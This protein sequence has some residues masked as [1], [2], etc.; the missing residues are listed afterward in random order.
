MR[1]TTDR[2]NAPQGGV[3]KQSGQRGD[4][5]FRD[6]TGRVATATEGEDAMTRT[7]LW[8]MAAAAVLV[9]AAGGPVPAEA[10]KLRGKAAGAT[11][12]TTGWD[13]SHRLHRDRTGPSGLR[14][15]TSQP[16]PKVQTQE[17]NFTHTLDK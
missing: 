1:R 3:Q 2:S 7:S 14:A 6:A 8:S 12:R 4:V 15:R 17:L 11:A 16:K 5:R 9:I 10:A 13:K